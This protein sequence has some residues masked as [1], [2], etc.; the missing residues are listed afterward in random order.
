MNIQILI[1]IKTKMQI[2][3]DRLI[4]NYSYPRNGC[5][6]EIRSARLFVKAHYFLGVKD[7]KPHNRKEADM[8]SRPRHV[9]QKVVYTSQIVHGNMVEQIKSGRYRQGT[10]NKSE[11]KKR[12]V[13]IYIR[14]IN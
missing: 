7:I 12:F 9:D 10:D 14:V 4:S 11:I 13:F 8:I 3:A 6:I 5:R 2:C 1:N